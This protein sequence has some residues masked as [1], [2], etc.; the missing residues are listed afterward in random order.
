MAQT[1]RAQRNKRR[2]YFQVILG[3]FLLMIVSY[4][5]F[6][7]ENWRIQKDIS[8]QEKLLNQQNKQ[9]DASEKRVEHSKLAAVRRLQANSNS[10][11]RSE[12][13][14]K[15]IEMLESLKAVDSSESET[16]VLSDFTVSLDTVSL[17]GKVSS[18]PLLYVNSEKRNY[19]ALL[20]KFAQL[21]FIDNLRIQT[22]EKSDGRDFEF[23]LD[24]NVTINNGT[25]E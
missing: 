5:Y 17:K 19:V 1:L 24:A 16:I 7:F 4:G 9:L 22:Y 10:I 2:S 14:P 12:H 21:D 23:V 20:D 15:I 25:G 8:T 18:L 11:P 13:L 3:I 6:R